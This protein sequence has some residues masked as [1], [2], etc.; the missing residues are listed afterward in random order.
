MP[1]SVP[2]RRR[3]GSRRSDA[4]ATVENEKGGPQGRPFFDMRR[5]SGYALKYMICVVVASSR[6]E[7]DHSLPD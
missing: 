7:G 1:T 2:P 6:P 5:N 3:S 4:T